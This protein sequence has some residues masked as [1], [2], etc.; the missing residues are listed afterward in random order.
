MDTNKARRGKQPPPSLPV[1]RAVRKLGNDLRDARRRRR[2]PTAVL[3]QRASI[4]RISLIRVEK[5][6]TGV[7]MGIY[8][9]V[10]MCLGMMDRLAD[11]AD[12][13]HDYMG[14]ALTDEQI[15]VR[16]RLPRRKD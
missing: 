13:R 10:L 9:S 8:A 2:I 14:I 12:P 15:P 3:A 5:G 1:I 6:D 7:S 4:S 16:I 11:L